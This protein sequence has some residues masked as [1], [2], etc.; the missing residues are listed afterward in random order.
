MTMAVAKAGVRAPELLAAAEVGPSAAVMAYRAP[1]GAALTPTGQTIL[2]EDDLAAFWQL[3]A[4]LQRARIAHRGLI[5]DHLLLDEHGRAALSEAGT[6]DIAAAELSLRLDVA[7]LLT[8]LALLVGPKRAVA[9]GVSSLGSPGHR[10][11]PATCPGGRDGLLDEVSPSS[12]EGLVAE[13][14]RAGA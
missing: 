12:A 7:Q 1:E 9:S 5:V 14:P 3:L 8:T 2:S 6:G 4:L 10:E 13:R 11:G